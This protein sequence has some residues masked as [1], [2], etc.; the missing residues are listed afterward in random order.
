MHSSVR[1]LLAEEHRGAFHI[2]VWQRSD[3]LEWS[4][5][6][7]G[8]RA[9][10]EFKHPDGT[11]A[12]STVIIKSMLHK[13]VRRAEEELMD[14]A[15][16]P[17]V[18]MYMHL[19]GEKDIA[20][21]DAASRA[22]A[23]IAGRACTAGSEDVGPGDL[24]VP[25]A[26]AALCERFPVQ[27][28]RRTDPAL[29]SRYLLLLARAMPRSG[30]RM[31]LV[32]FLK[33]RH[34]LPPST[35]TADLA[36][37]VVMEE[38]PGAFPSG[39]GPV[40]GADAVAR[41]CVYGDLDR[42]LSM[43]RRTIT[44]CKDVGREAS[45][46]ECTKVFGAI[47]KTLRADSSVP[48]IC[49]RVVTALCVV[50]KRLKNTESCLH[51]ISA[52]VVANTFNSREETT[53]LRECLLR[54]YQEQMKLGI[55]DPEE[56]AAEISVECELDA[57]FARGGLM[58][59]ADVPVYCLDKHT[60]AKGADRSLKFFAEKGAMVVRPHPHAEED[61]IHQ[62]LLE[63]YNAV[64]VT[65]DKLHMQ[66]KNRNRGQGRKRVASKESPGSDAPA[67]KRRPA[68]T[69]FRRYNPELVLGQMPCTLETKRLVIMYPKW[70]LKGPYTDRSMLA[71]ALSVVMPHVLRMVSQ[72]LDLNCGYSWEPV[73]PC[74]VDYDAEGVLELCTVENEAGQVVKTLT[75]K[76]YWLQFP[77]AGKGFADEEQMMR[78]SE[79]KENPSPS[80]KC[81]RVLPRN[82]SAIDTRLGDMD[83][84]YSE[85]ANP[86]NVGVLIAMMEALIARSVAG[87]G[88]SGPGNFLCSLERGM[89]EPMI[90]VMDF[91]ESAGVQPR[92][93][94]D[95]FPSMAAWL[96][97]RRKST[98]RAG[99]AA[100]VHEFLLDKTT[101]NMLRSIYKRRRTLLELNLPWMRTLLLDS[102]KGCM[103][104]KEE[105][106][107]E[108]VD[109][110]MT[111]IPSGKKMCKNMAGL[112][113]S[114]RATAKAVSSQ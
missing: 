58:C 77:M 99:L 48:E 30:Y 54:G 66:S 73:E 90:R 62:E 14:A 67:L 92:K 47:M 55:P 107:K 61:G 80:V 85:D 23:N 84:F 57:F 79:L 34:A 101:R 36:R 18:E 59:M 45:R 6:G 112:W 93:N 13:A 4:P 63:I 37:N 42:A 7:V 44:V 102:I 40:S 83:T 53:R 76:G 15:V 5:K 17:V 25:L 12:P 91:E 96:F 43:L 41:E 32:S 49:V 33:A 114:Y 50:F 74:A 27:T 109:L 94:A 88:D 8:A 60:G 98:L 52:V 69:R 39:S 24:F 105:F 28:E 70:P 75:S 78:E 20:R 16:M 29:Y 111:R 1:V 103:P 3:R 100:E 110:A 19:S 86:P 71:L 22:F 65:I 38:M 9:C 46:P 82:N 87:S 108:L 68:P 31:R 72:K 104:G 10:V 26:M 21:R 51:L 95:A 89:S 64:K 97:Q 2:F 113:E 81:V 11:P 35:K 56:L 106:A